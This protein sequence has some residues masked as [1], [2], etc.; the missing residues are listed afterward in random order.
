[1]RG[2][3]GGGAVSLHP[4]TY[5]SVVDTVVPPGASHPSPNFWAI[6]V[7]HLTGK[8]PWPQRLSLPRIPS[9]RDSGNQSWQIQEDKALLSL[10]LSFSLPL[11]P[12]TSICVSSEETSQ[13]RITHLHFVLGLAEDS[14]TATLS[15]VF[16]LCPHPAILTCFYGVCWDH[17]LL[18]SPHR[19]FCFPKRS[20]KRYLLLDT[21]IG[22]SAS[23]KY[24]CLAEHCC[25]EQSSLCFPLG[26]GGCCRESGTQDCVGKSE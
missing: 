25:R 21:Q 8:G 6:T 26:G 4:V 20:A 3:P 18:N 14:V 1:M 15:I 7:A 13:L 10:P 5:A 9:P 23:H 22:Q 17:L 24:C 19:I 11:L 2:N 12:L 16:S